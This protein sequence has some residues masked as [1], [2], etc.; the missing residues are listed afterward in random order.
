MA[1][2]FLQATLGNDVTFAAQKL[3]ELTL[4][5]YLIKNRCSWR[6]ED[7]EVDVRIRAILCAGNRPKDPDVKCSISGQQALDFLRLT[8]DVFANA[9]HQV[10]LRFAVS[11]MG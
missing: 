3:G 2:A 4:E 11:G 8:K 9:A 10:S 7:Q 1:V 5:M 6:K